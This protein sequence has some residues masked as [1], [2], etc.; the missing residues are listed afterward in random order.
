MLFYDANNGLVNTGQFDSSGNWQTLQGF[1]VYKG[2]TH[3][4]SPGDA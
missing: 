4:T 2:W 3:Q 1:P